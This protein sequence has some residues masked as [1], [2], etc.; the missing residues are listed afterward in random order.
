MVRA[1]SRVILSLA[2][3][4]AA[5]WTGVAQAQ[6]PFVNNQ[7]LFPGPA[8][9]LAPGSTTTYPFVYN[10]P[11][12]PTSTGALAPV[13]VSMRFTPADPFVYN[14]AGFSVSSGPD[15]LTR[16]AQP[17]ALGGTPDA[18]SDTSGLKNLFISS[19][20]T[21]NWSI[22]VF[23]YSAVP[24]QYTLQSTVE[25]I[26]I[27][28][29]SGSAAGA[30]PGGAT[31]QASASG[32][33]PPSAGPSAG[34][35]GPLPVVAPAPTAALPAAAP[36]YPVVPAAPPGPVTPA[37]PSLPASTAATGAVGAAPVATAQPAI[38][39][40]QNRVVTGALA[41]G[42]QAVYT[43]DYQP[44][45]GGGGN[46]SPWL[47]S[48]RSSPAGVTPDSISFNIVGVQGSIKGIVL[49]HSSQAA[50]GG[51]PDAQGTTDTNGVVNA[52]LAYP[53]PGPYQVVVSNYSGHSTSYQLTLFPMIGSLVEPAF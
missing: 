23:N 38:L 51:T 19:Q 36:A 50:L 4:L 30:P 1:V 32:A 13:L 47:L 52:F 8:G 16:T 53:V 41:D 14:A 7:T 3:G 11:V 35:A 45:F 37:A 39:T 24:I 22:T 42:A 43:V 6:A 49:K 26:P 29:A 10:P 44:R 34:P 12:S 21:G 27:L 2:V 20:K 31:G 40:R 18:Y 15:G 28:T 9:T 46:L 25:P 48:L 17:A 5:L 33:A